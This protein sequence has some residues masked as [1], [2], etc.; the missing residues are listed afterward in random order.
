MTI[1]IQKNIKKEKEIQIIQKDQ[2]K[3]ID[4]MYKTDKEFECMVGYEKVNGKNLSDQIIDAWAEW[5]FPDDPE[6]KEN[7]NGR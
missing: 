5:I 4:K 1:L 3:S 7:K 2:Y 6:D